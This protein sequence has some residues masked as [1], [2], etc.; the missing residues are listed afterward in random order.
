[1]DLNVVNEINKTCPNLQNLLNNLWK[2]S[3]GIASFYR[4]ISLVPAPNTLQ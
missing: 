1:M 3:I 2:N 4:Q